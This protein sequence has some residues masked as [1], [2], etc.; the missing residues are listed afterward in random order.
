MRRSAIAALSAITL[1]S[2]ILM[3]ILYIKYDP[4]IEQRNAAKE[5][6]SAQWRQ[7]IT[8]V[9]EQNKRLNQPPSLT[10]SKRNPE[11][12]GGDGAGSE[13]TVPSDVGTPTVT[14]T[15]YQRPVIATP[16]QPKSDPTAPSYDELARYPDK[17][18]G[19]T[20]HLSGEVLQIINNNEYLIS[21][22]KDGLVWTDNVYIKIKGGTELAK[23]LEDDIIEVWGYGGGEKAYT[24]VLGQRRTVP[25][26]D[27][28]RVD[29]VTKAGDR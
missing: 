9:E 14:P 22:T 17:Y 23:V 6:A 7:L 12:G 2:A 21:I 5:A 11:G 18:K 24:S 19:R 25:A 8:R 27:A 28:Y 13:Y 3:V 1:G 20:V 10:P 16:E 29:V 4:Y 26:V 15:G